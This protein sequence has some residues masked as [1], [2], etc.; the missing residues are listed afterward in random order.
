MSKELNT[1]LKPLLQ[2]GEEPSLFTLYQALQIEYEMG[3][4]LSLVKEYCLQTVSEHN[5]IVGMEFLYMNDF[6]KELEQAI[7]DNLQSQQSSNQNWAKVYDLILKRRRQQID[8]FEIL[9]RLRKIKTEDNALLTMI[10]FMKIYVHLDL[11][12]YNE[13][14]NYIDDITEGMEAFEDPLFKKYYQERLDDF[15]MFYYLFRN[16]LILC[17]K[18]GFRLLNQSKNPYKL[19]T[20]HIVIGHSYARENYEQSIYHFYR[21]KDLAVTFNQ[22]MAKQI[23]NQ[24]IPFVS[25]LNGIY[26]GITTDDEAEQAHLAIAAGRADEAIKTLEGFTNRTPFQE[27][28]LGKAKQSE[29][30]LKLAYRQFKQSGNFFI[31]KLPLLEL[32]RL[33]EKGAASF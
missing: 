7:E 13:V 32:E 19:S 28:Y 18:H 14:G 25:A 15:W 1:V 30:H 33:K 10:S 31:A 2:S 4:V 3:R 11:T 17:R 27:Y 22:Q 16:E 21:A 6:L 8:P 20:T 29:F 24:N 9:K 23:I 5:K 12:Q 26:E